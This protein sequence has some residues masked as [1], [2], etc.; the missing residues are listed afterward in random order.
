MEQQTLGT[1][2]VSTIEGRAKL[3]DD[4]VT[5][6][7]NRLTYLYSRWQDEKAYEDFLD[8]RTE[9]E[10]IVPEGFSFVSAKRRPFGMSVSYGPYKFEVSVKAKSI[11]WKRI[12]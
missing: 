6:V 11:Q 2:D 5:R 7:E 1:V 3:M 12:K 9:M 4:F 10:K 8:Y